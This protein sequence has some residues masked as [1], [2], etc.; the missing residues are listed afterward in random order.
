[1]LNYRLVKILINRMLNNKAKMFLVSFVD[2]NNSKVTL[3]KLKFHNIVVLCKPISVIIPVILL[4]LSKT[5]PYDL[6]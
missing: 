2:T 4:C 1:M 6:F 5:S 3:A